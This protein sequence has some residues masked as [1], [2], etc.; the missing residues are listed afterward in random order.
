MN[1]FTDAIRIQKALARKGVRV[2]PLEAYDSWVRYSLSQSEGWIDIKKSTKDE[3]I[4]RKVRNHIREFE[5]PAE[6]LKVKDKVEEKLTVVKNDLSN[7]GKQELQKIRRYKN[8]ISSFGNFM[9]IP[10]F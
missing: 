7:L 3:T 9:K 4:Y 1:K 5:E 2:S 8:I 6:L 10:S